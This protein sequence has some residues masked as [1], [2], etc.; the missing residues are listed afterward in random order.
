MYDDGPDALRS[1]RLAKLK[2]LGLIGDITPHPFIKE[3]SEGV[4]HEEWEDLTAEERAKSARSMECFAGMVDNMDQN[5]G[6]VLDYLES[7][8]EA[9]SKHRTWNRGTPCV[10]LC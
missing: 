10:H 8:G 7:T 5:I 1:K 6:K 4:M 2:E 9:D 3:D